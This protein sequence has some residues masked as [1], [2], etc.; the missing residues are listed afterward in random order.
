[1]WLWWYF[2]DSLRSLCL[3]RGLGHWAPLGTF[4]THGAHNNVVFECGINIRDARVVLPPNSGLV[5]S[6]I[7]VCDLVTDHL[8]V[9]SEDIGHWTWF[10]VASKNSRTNVLYVRLLYDV[11]YIIGCCVSR[12]C[13]SG[14]HVCPFWVGALYKEICTTKVTHEQYANHANFK[15]V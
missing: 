10:L 4:Y 7:H 14:C 6:N 5:W 15:S 13:I 2:N 9:A 3:Q 12:F 11:W 1:M 8:D